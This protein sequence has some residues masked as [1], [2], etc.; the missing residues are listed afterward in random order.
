L[1]LVGAVCAMT[2]VAARARS[3]GPTTPGGVFGGPRPAWVDELALELSETQEPSANGR[4]VLLWDTQVRCTAQGDERYVR[5]AQRITNAG[6]LAAAA[7]LTVEFDPTFQTVTVHNV[8]LHRG[9]TLIPSLDLGSVKVMQREPRLEQQIY[10]G[11]RTAVL[12]VPDVRV[13]DVL[14]WDFSTKGRDPLLGGRCVTALGLG[15]SEPVARLRARLSAALGSKIVTTVHGTDEKLELTHESGVEAVYQ[16]SRVHVPAYRD[17]PD[18]PPWYE[19]VPWLQVTDF[20][21]WRSVAQWAAAL[22]ETSSA[23]GPAVAELAQHL[24]KSGTSTDE[25]VLAA[26]RFVQD[27]IRYVGL[28]VGLART[29]PASAR[30]VLARRFGDCK[31]KTMLLVG[32]LRAGG[33]EAAPALVSTHGERALR[34]WAPSP[35]AFD[36]AIARVGPLD[37]KI[38]YID[39]TARGAGGGLAAVSDSFFGYALALRG[40]G[41]DLEDM[42]SARAASGLTIKDT[43]LVTL[44]GATDETTLET[45]HAY[46]GL[47]ANHM[48]RLFEVLSVEQLSRLYLGNYAQSY[49]GIRELVPPEKIDDRMTNEVRVRGRYAVP[50]F[51]TTNAARER[52]E[53]P[54]APPALDLVLP[55]PAKPNRSA[56]L[57]IHHPFRLSHTIAAQL[58]F[59]VQLAALKDEVAGPGFV[60]TAAQDY[61]ERRLVYAFGLRTSADAIETQDFAGYQAALTKASP[62]LHRQLSYVSELFGVRAINWLA[63]V[64]LVVA[65]GLTVWIVVRGSRPSFSTGTTQRVVSAEIPPLGG[66][67]VV[68]GLQLVVT[69]AY[70]ARSLP[71]YA[72]LLARQRW[73]GLV[74]SAAPGNFTLGVF[75]LFLAAVQVLIIGYALLVLVLFVQRRRRFCPHYLALVWITCVS[76]LLDALLTPWITDAT[77]TLPV[78][79]LVASTVGGSILWTLYVVHSKRV[80]RTFVVD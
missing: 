68:I 36:H 67:L 60:I 77:R 71:T 56:P 37:G 65:F 18:A 8:V 80:A 16:V 23:N 3:P 20:D 31:E 54:L 59:D 7:Q 73:L 4:Q 52:E 30:E 9:P 39:P 35:A 41:S 27:E 66:W 26:T 43:Y 10:D 12:F 34:K 48:R 55:Q 58:P 74:T 51:W 45:E 47:L 19:P 40:P 49:P 53:G 2:T 79:S 44:P 24:R 57:A 22:F 17:E 14:E 33:V 70:R 5:F 76:S 62:L 72:W 25:F 38:Y 46:T 13:G 1:A 69:L 21:S 50:G 6:G 15:A 61:A 42:D 63:V 32:L 78:P 29:V 11:R 75:A 64:V 28:E